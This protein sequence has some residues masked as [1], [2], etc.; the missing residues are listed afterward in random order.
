MKLTILTATYNRADLLPQLYE[1]IVNNLYKELDIEWLIMD[2]GSTDNTKAVI[3]SF[4]DVKNLTVRY[5]SQI[6]H[7]K[8]QALNNLIGFATGDLILECDSDD[9]IAEDAFRTIYDTYQRNK[10]REDLYAFAFLKHDK[11]DQNIGQD[12]IDN[13]VTT[14]FDL[15]FKDGEDGEKALVFIAKIRKNYKYELAKNERFV[16]EASMF[17]RMDEDYNI[18]CINWPIMI[19]EYR[20]DGYTKNINK[21]FRENPYGFYNYFQYLSSRNLKDIK[22]G[23]KM[24]IIK[25]YILFAYLTKQK[26]SLKQV[27]KLKDKFLLGLLYLPG[28]IVSKFKFGR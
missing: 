11:N 13:K 17:Y 5:Y 8:M 26:I 21:V 12:L 23:K 18:F 25:H 4:K 10:K 28:L 6:N 9:L 2:D 16:T 22:F 3:N 27:R 24:Y 1:S 14:M 7:G 15:Y 19:C 20:S